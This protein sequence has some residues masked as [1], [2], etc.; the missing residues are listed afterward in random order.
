MSISVVIKIVNNINNFYYKI[1]TTTECMIILQ[2]IH[3][4]MDK[5]NVYT[6]LIYL[7]DIP[8][9]DKNTCLLNNNDSYVEFL[10]NCYRL[11]DDL[12]NYEQK[13]NDLMTKTNIDKFT[14]ILTLDTE[15]RGIIEKL[16][17][18]SKIQPFKYIIDDINYY[19]DCE[20]LF[21][22]GNVDVKSKIHISIDL[23]EVIRYIEHLYGMI[24]I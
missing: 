16:E 9:Y 14:L 8:K 23:P 24:K 15:I 17:S 20:Y 18:I 11:F 5:N 2:G 13:I 19:G 21:K 12:I 3:K 22:Q 6:L 10:F 7:S 1:N 4:I